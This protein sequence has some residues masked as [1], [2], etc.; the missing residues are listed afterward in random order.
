MNR[1]IN[2]LIVILILAIIT[3]GFYF[4]NQQA[5]QYF[6]TSKEFSMSLGYLTAIFA[7]IGFLLGSIIGIN[8][9]L[10]GRKAKSEN[11]KKV[12]DL[13]RQLEGMRMSL[14]TLS[15]TLL[16]TPNPANEKAIDII[17]GTLEDI[18]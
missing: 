13:E 14:E 8:L 11:E 1:I 9:A 5:V 18:K 10:K 4:N 12:Y 3:I 15:N 17:E 2:F 6:I 16:K 7:F